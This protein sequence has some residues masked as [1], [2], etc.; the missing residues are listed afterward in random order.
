MGTYITNDIYK[1]LK[2]LINSLTGFEEKGQTARHFKLCEKFVLSN[3]KNHNYL[4]INSHIVRRSVN[5]LKEKFI[6][7][8][9]YKVAE[10]FTSLVDSLLTSSAFNFDQHPQHDLQW[11]LLSLLIELSNETSKSIISTGDDSIDA[12]DL[13][14][15]D[16]SDENFDSR[17][18]DLND[19]RTDEINWEEYLKEGQQEFFTGSSQSTLKKK[20]SSNC[21]AELSLKSQ[22]KSRSLEKFT[23][24]VESQKWLEL[25]VENTWWSEKNYQNVQ[26]LSVFPQAHFC[27][28]YESFRQSTSE[29][30]K[31]GT[32]LISE[33]Q[34]CREVLWMLTHQAVTSSGDYDNI[35]VVYEKTLDEFSVNKNISIPSLTPKAF[36]SAFG[37]FVEYFSM[38]KKLNCLLENTDINTSNI[39]SLFPITY[40]NYSTSVMQYFNRLKEDIIDVEKKSMQRKFN[41]TTFLTLSKDLEPIVGQLSMLSD[42]HRSVLT[43]ELLKSQ[44]NW[45]KSYRLLLNLYRQVENSSSRSRTNLCASLYL[46][47]LK[48]Y[49][50]IIDTWLTEGR[51]EDFRDEF[52]VFKKNFSNNFESTSS[53]DGDRI[54]MASFAIRPIEKDGLVIDPITKKLLRKIEEM[55]RN[56]DLLVTLNRISDM[57]KMNAE[58]YDSTRIPLS[59]EFISYVIMELSKYGNDS[60]EIDHSDQLDAANV[61]YEIDRSTNASDLSKVLVKETDTDNLDNGLDAACLINLEENIRQQIRQINNPFLMKV[62][63]NYLPSLTTPTLSFVNF[64]A[65]SSVDTVDFREKNLEDRREVRTQ[66]GVINIF[67]KLEGMSEFILPFRKALETTLD[68]ILDRRYSCA[69]KLVKNILIDEYKLERHLKLMRSIYMMERGH[70]MRKF[71]QLMFQEIETGNLATYRINPYGDLTNILEQVLSDEWR[72][73]SSQNRWSITIVPSDG[74]NTTRQVIQAIENTTLDYSVDWPINMVLAEPVLVKYNEIFRFQLKLKW[75]LWTLNNLLFTDLEGSSEDMK[76]FFFHFNARRL[77]CLRFWLL[78]AIGSIHTYLSGQV[79]QSLGLILENSLAQAKDL[80]TIIQIHNDYLDKAHEHCLQ[81]PQFADIMTTINNL[82]EM[83][84]HIRDRWKRGVKHLMPQEL[85]VMEKKYIKFHTYLALALHNAVQHKEADYLA[86]LTTA[87]NCNK[88]GIITSI[89]SNTVNQTSCVDIQPLIKSLLAEVAHQSYPPSGFPSTKIF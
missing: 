79:L 68:T 57:W 77:E 13:G 9:N 46:S 70:V 25:N 29:A 48:I 38:V 60:S 78:H 72:D 34:A 58:I 28:I 44:T 56:I 5:D 37:S 49:L 47:S 84:A 33:Y 16:E 40:E 15:D 55:G 14:S 43:D 83:C 19:S 31:S 7:H 88:S 81:T 36:Q 54:K 10:R 8:G 26:V 35:G 41:P 22:A 52:L 1:D 59:E 85:D 87:F 62:F 11:T 66:W 71:Y 75:A 50:N 53:E 89:S 74:G 39:K 32:S 63:Q 6:V 80:D 51:L 82:L 23:R 27:E 64:P 42:I 45:E 17:T 2:L 20:S 12:L 86:S 24:I 4:P 21:P 30:G 3:I 73:S 76:D 61:D 67:D 18:V 65:T 69:S